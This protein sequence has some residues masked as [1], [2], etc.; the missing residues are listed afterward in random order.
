[1][2]IYTYIKRIPIMYYNINH[3]NKSGF[4]L[5]NKWDVSRRVNILYRKKKAYFTYQGRIKVWFINEAFINII[6]KGSV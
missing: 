6:V 2:F 4:I 3:L 1:M 5:L